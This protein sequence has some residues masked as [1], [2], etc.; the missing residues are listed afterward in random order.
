MRESVIQE[1]GILHLATDSGSQ[2]AWW[3]IL[4]MRLKVIFSKCIEQGGTTMSLSSLYR[5]FLLHFQKR[6]ESPP[7]G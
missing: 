7:C 6:G 4:A 5:H 3:A 2:V 1:V